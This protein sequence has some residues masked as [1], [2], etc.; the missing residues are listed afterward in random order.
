MYFDKFYFFEKEKEFNKAGGF[1]G[2]LFNRKV[3]VN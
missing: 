1:G 2:R 3:S